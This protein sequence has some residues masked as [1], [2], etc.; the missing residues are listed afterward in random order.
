[1]IKNKLHCCL[2]GCLGYQ[3]IIINIVPLTVL[4]NI[5]S[6]AMIILYDIVPFTLLLK[7]NAIQILHGL[8]LVDS[9]G[10]VFSRSTYTPDI[11]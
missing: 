4:S 1:M 7:L 3:Y 11:A 8:R 9:A 2:R 6:S 5:T 10:F